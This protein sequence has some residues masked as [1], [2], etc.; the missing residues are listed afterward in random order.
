MIPEVEVYWK[1]IE[2]LRGQVLALIDGLPAEA[3]NWRPIEG[4]G[5][6]ATN[7]MAALATH[8]AGAEHFWIGE[9]VGGKPPTRNRD[10]EFASQADDARALIR[11]LGEVGAETH[12]VLSRLDEN[13]IEGARQAR[14]RTIPV[15]WCILHVVDH[16]ALHLGHMQ[17][18][19]QLWMGGKGRP[20]P[21]WFERLDRQG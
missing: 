20:S 13:E 8:V 9:V 14:G 7:S 1:R 2:D 19:Y 16:T 11:I 15:R 17:L 21:R 5:E 4:G 10:A 12:G 3:L 18:T 6:H